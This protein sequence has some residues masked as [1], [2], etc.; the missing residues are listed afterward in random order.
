[1]G[2]QLGLVRPTPLP[3]DIL[4]IDPIDIH[5]GRLA[6]LRL[7]APAPVVALGV[8]LFSYLRLKLTLR[9]QGF[10]AELHDYDWRLSVAELGRTLAARL[11]SL[12]PARLAIVAHSMGN[13][14][15]IEV[16]RENALLRKNGGS[17]QDLKLNEVVLAA[18]DVSRTVFE[19]FAAAFSGLP[20]GGITLFAS[21]NDRALCFGR[22][23]HV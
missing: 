9:A 12:A 20:K 18:P 17:T 11:R 14:P 21:S 7:P 15:V 2:S 5:L 4:W 3:N 1:M 19:Q 23:R 22:R 13:N 6:R 10:A 8:V 16:L